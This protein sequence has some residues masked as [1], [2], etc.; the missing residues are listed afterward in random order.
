MV[1][2]AVTGPL[3]NGTRR[4]ASLSELPLKAE[5]SE[6]EYAMGA[7]VSTPDAVPFSAWMAQSVKR[8]CAR[9]QQAVEQCWTH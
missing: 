8:S 2:A 9:H 6:V 3:G 1:D 7:K 5:F 4:R